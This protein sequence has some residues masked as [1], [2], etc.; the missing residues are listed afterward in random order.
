MY[1]CVRKRGGE[2][3]EREEVGGGRERELRGEERERGEGGG[4]NTLSPHICDEVILLR[5][6]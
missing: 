6:I 2:G 4:A 1:V 5:C 3:G